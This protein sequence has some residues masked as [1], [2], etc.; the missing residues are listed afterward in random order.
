MLLLDIAREAIE[1]GDYIYFLLFAML[2]LKE[3]HLFVVNHSEAFK[4]GEIHAAGRAA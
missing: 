4:Y 2:G 1:M 3:T